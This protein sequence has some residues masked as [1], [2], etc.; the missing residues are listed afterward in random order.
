MGKKEERERR[1]TEWTKRDLKERVK[2]CKGETEGKRE[3][4]R[5]TSRRVREIIVTE[6][7]HAKVN[8]SKQRIENCIR[9]GSRADVCK[10]K[11][12]VR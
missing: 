4:S 2:S 12:A 7:Q 5:A 3:K 6:E 8:P 1:V 9:S 11:T 10:G